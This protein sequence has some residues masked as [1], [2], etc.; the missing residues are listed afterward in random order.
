M[1]EAFSPE[2]AVSKVRVESNTPFCLL[3]AVWSALPLHTLCQPCLM[4]HPV[5]A[6]NL[7]G[8]K[9]N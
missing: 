5:L 6:L 7:Q 8:R 9:Q 2:M 4:G 3:V 1:E